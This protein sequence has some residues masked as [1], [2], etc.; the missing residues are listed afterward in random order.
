[1]IGWRL[2]IYSAL[3]SPL[4][5]AGATIPSLAST[6]SNSCLLSI[7]GQQEDL[8]KLLQFLTLP[9]AP[10][11]QTH[12]KVH[13]KNKLLH[14]FLLPHTFLLRAP[15]SQN[16]ASNWACLESSPWSDKILTLFSL[17]EHGTCKILTCLGLTQA[18]P[19][20]SPYVCLIAHFPL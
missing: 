16:G 8:P 1:M 6:N 5:I 7:G 4:S 2:T 3:R 20:L 14:I 19:I 12:I 17:E 18:M 10:R 9:H 15:K 13:P 11:R